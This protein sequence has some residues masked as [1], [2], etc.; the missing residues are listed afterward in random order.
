MC[1][2]F[3][4]MSTE[5]LV[6]DL[7]GLDAL[8][9][10]MVPTLEIRDVVFDKM[11]VEYISYPAIWLNDLETLKDAY[12]TPGATSPVKVTLMQKFKEGQSEKQKYTGHRL[13]LPNAGFYTCK[14]WSSDDNRVVETQK[15]VAIKQLDIEMSF[16]WL[17]NKVVF[18]TE[19]RLEI[20][21]MNCLWMITALKY[22]DAA[23]KDLFALS[24][25]PPNNVQRPDPAMASIMFHDSRKGTR[26]CTQAEIDTKLLAGVAN[27]E[28]SQRH[29]EIAE[30]E[31]HRIAEQNLRERTQLLAQCSSTL[32]IALRE[33]VGEPR[34]VVSVSAVRLLWEKELGRRFTLDHV[35]P[36]DIH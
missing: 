25:R 22:K 36:A 11:P 3:D 29:F 8:L 14:I 27:R 10:H 16:A 30:L 21:K 32:Q 5:K 12:N 15:P 31:H 4:C 28:S 2:L 6:K 26:Y 17:L 35:H 24:P 34:T 9:A 18:F 20:L 7:N 19:Q 23:M 1:T 13:S 33:G